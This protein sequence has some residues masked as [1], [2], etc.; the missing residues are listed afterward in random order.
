MVQISFPVVLVNSHSSTIPYCT[1]H[2]ITGDVAVVLPNHGSIDNSL[3]CLPVSGRGV[4]PCKGRHGAFLGHGVGI[5]TVAFD[6]ESL[7]NTK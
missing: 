7:Q 6:C 1:I 2:L 5:D 3:H 4:R